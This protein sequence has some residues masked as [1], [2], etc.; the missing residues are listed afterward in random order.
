MKRWTGVLVALV[1]VFA[2]VAAVD[3]NRFGNDETR[4][5][6]AEQQRSAPEAHIPVL[7]DSTPHTTP[8]T[9]AVMVVGKK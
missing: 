5:S 4:I 3:S 7:E 9:A 8:M 1:V 6:A 2:L